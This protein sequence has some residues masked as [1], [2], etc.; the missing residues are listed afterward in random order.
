MKKKSVQAVKAVKQP[1]RKTRSATVSK[2][3]KD[4]INNV[5]PAELD[6]YDRLLKQVRINQAKR[7][8]AT[9]NQSKGKKGKTKRQKVLLKWK[10]K[11][12]RVTQK[13]SSFK[14]RTIL[15]NMKFQ[16]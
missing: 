8:A 5:E 16:G 6:A 11:K 12:M 14:M 9:P 4:D 10:F 7:A 2:Q 3:A 15:W 13:L 1:S